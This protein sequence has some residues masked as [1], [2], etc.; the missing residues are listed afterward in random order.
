M[1][2]VGPAVVHAGITLTARTMPWQPCRWC[3]PE[4]KAHTACS[5]HKLQYSRVSKPQAKG[6]GMAKVYLSITQLSSVPERLDTGR[7]RRKI[8]EA[9]QHTCMQARRKTYTISPLSL[10]AVFIVTLS[11]K[12]ASSIRLALPRRYF[13]CHSAQKLYSNIVIN[14]MNIVFYSFSL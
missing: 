7:P 6:K 4:Y 3:Q 1:I 12:N 5:Q 9:T 13:S 10:V 2:T 14:M 8:S 11:M